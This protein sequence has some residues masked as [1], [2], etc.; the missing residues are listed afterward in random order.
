MQYVHLLYTVTSE[1]HNKKIFSKGLSA[2]KIFFFSSAKSKI[3]SNHSKGN[4]FL[5][6]SVDD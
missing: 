3:H 1:H 4:L 6:H 5:I 2:L